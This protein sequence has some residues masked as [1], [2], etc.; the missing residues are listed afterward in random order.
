MPSAKSDTTPYWSTSATFP[1]DAQVIETPDGLPYIGRSADHQYSATGYVGNG[2][3]FGTLAGIM[4]SD[5]VLG[6]SNPWSE[7][8][9]PGRKALARGLW[10]YVKENVDYPYY[11]IRD[12]FAGAEA[13][14]LRAVR[15]G[16]GKVIE[17][18]GAKVA[19]YRDTAGTVTLRSPSARTWDARWA[20][21]P[22]SGPGTARVMG[23]ASSRVAR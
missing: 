19:A 13:K 11:M 15:R 23:H 7:L 21:T 10:D 18:K 14:S 2:L 20:G 12:R 9:D 5:A 3:T 17:R 16:E 8:F 4:I 6:R 22:P 1:Q